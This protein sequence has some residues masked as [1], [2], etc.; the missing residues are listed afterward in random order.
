[1]EAE[2]PEILRHCSIEFMQANESKFSPDGALPKHVQDT[3]RFIR[4]GQVGDGLRHLDGAAL[5]AYNEQLRAHFGA[6]VPG[7]NERMT[8]LLPKRSADE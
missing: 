2:L 6:G 5:S 4:K 3:T 1:V 8:I 7:Q